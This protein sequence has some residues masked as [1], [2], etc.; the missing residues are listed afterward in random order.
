MGGSGP[1]TD[2]HFMTMEFMQFS[3]VRPRA[4][5][6]YSGF[7]GAQATDNEIVHGLWENSD[8]TNITRIDF[9]VNT[10]T[11]DF[12]VWVFKGATS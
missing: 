7:A 8:N 12:R 6:Q 10:G 9:S 2:R 1:N 5:Y 3:A 11:A 4:M